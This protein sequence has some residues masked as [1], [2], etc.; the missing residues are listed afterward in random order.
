MIFNTRL[1]KPSNPEFFLMPA[2]PQLEPSPAYENAH[3]I[4]RDLLGDI[5][6]Q[7]DLTVKP[8]D[9]N[10]RWHHARTMN[11]INAQLSDVAD[12][13]DTLNNRDR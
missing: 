10:L 3:L 13:L 4:A 6:R 11:R 12:A 9:P 2:K 7:L 8:D 1:L 5:R